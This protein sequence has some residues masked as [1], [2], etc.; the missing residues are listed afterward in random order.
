MRAHTTQITVDGER[1]ALSNDIAQEIDAVEYFTL[2][3]GSP[4]KADADG[5]ESDLFAGL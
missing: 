5:Y 1:F 4:P 2:L 3:M